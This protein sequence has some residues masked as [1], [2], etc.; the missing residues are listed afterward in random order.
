[1]SDWTTEYMTL[2]DDCEARE[3]R[4]TDWERRFLDDI[5]AHIAVGNHPSPKQ[6]EKLDEVW[7]RVTAKG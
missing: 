3:E 6:T 2:I 1:M 7:E 5:K 4:L